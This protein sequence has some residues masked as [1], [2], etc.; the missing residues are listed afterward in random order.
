[1]CWWEQL[2]VQLWLKIPNFINSCFC[3][4]K[5]WMI[6]HQN[7]GTSSQHCRE[8]WQRVESEPRWMDF[9]PDSVLISSGIAAGR[10]GLRVL[11]IAWGGCSSSPWEHCCSQMGPGNTV[12]VLLPQPLNESFSGCYWWAKQR[13]G[14]TSSSSSGLGCCRNSPAVHGANWEQHRAREFLEWALPSCLWCFPQ[15]TEDRKNCQVLQQATADLNMCQLF[16][17]A[18]WGKKPTQF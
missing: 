13:A 18:D 17:P 5:V 11:F 4:W 14:T 9:K 2:E 7:T 6:V 16:L 15:I 1:M 12:P 8:L 10:A 3:Q